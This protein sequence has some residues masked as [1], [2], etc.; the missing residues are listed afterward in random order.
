MEAPHAAQSIGKER[1]EVDENNDRTYRIY[2]YLV[3]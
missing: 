3:E 1:E 2:N